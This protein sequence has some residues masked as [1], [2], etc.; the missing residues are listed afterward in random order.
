VD[1]DKSFVGAALKRRHKVPRRP[2]FPALVPRLIAAVAALVEGSGAESAATRRLAGPHCA[3]LVPRLTQPRW[4]LHRV[5]ISIAEALHRHLKN[6]E[7]VINRHLKNLESVINR[8][9]KNL[10]SVILYM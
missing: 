6:L 2:P 8:H 10:E 7:S 9:L 5:A 3:A 1:T 4:P